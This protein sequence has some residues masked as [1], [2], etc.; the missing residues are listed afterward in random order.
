MEHD[1]HED[2]LRRLD[3]LY[4]AVEY[5]DETSLDAAARVVATFLPVLG[6]DV[7]FVAAPSSSGDALEVARV[8][9]FSRA[10]VRLAFPLDAPYPLAEAIRRRRSLFIA[11]NEQLACDHPGLVRVQAEDHACATVPLF[12]DA[13][14]ILG[15]VNVAFDEPHPFGDDELQLVEILARRCAAVLAVGGSATA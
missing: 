14:Q 3:P 6:A 1:V 12:D 11:S 2:L 9:Q 8:T 7:G 10:P 15:A 4:A 5:Q 13:D